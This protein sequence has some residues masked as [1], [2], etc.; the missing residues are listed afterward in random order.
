MEVPSDC[1]RSQEAITIIS[2]NQQVSTEVRIEAPGYYMGQGITPPG[3]F[4]PTIRAIAFREPIV[5]N[6]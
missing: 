6:Q 2:E 1:G 3:E 5:K 4:K